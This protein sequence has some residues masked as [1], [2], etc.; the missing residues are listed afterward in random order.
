MRYL[1]TGLVFGDP[2]WDD[3]GLTGELWDGSYAK[4]M[5]GEICSVRWVYLGVTEDGENYTAVDP[6]AFEE[7]TENPDV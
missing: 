3:D 1:E 5:E 4:Y 6:S 2:I 7:D